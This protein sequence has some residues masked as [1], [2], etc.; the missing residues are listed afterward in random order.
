M[1]GTLFPPLISDFMNLLDR[2]SR[3]VKD[4]SSLVYM[5]H[6][7]IHSVGIVLLQML[8]GLSVTE[9]FSN[10]HTA[11]QFCK[12]MEPY[13]FPIA[14]PDAACLSPAVVSPALSRHAITMLAP[15]KNSHVSCLTLLGD[16]A[17]TSLQVIARRTPAIPM[18]AGPGMPVSVKESGSPDLRY[19]RG[20]PRQSQGSRWKEDWEELEWLGKGAFG[21]VVKARNKI[22]SRIYAGMAKHYSPHLCFLKMGL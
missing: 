20:P 6:R 10:V 17:E 19:F 14:M 21:S 8:I 15:S 9:R 7:D 18:S 22:D 4:G 3:G 13:L 5:R 2:L 16:L 12:N 1:N 11:L